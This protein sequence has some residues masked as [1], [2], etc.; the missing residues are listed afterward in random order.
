MQEMKP[1][2]NQ[3]E[4]AGLG[5]QLSKTSTL[6]EAKRRCCSHRTALHFDPHIGQLY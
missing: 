4:V 2:V 5:Q 6:L 1:E 3:T